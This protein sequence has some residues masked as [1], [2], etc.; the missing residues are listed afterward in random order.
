ME[1]NYNQFYSSY[2]TYEGSRTIDYKALNISLMA[3]YYLFLSDKSKIFIKGGVHSI[4][5][6][7]FNSH[8]FFQSNDDW[9]YNFVV[10]EQRPNI[11]MGVGTEY[12]RFF[13]E[14]EYFTNQNVL[15]N[16]L[17]VPTNL[18]R[19]SLSIGYKIFKL[20]SKDK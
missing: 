15:A 6:D 18:S 10:E 4:Y 1:S 19:L 17:S 12:R 20:S 13:A 3:K 8:Y 5:A 7:N 9:I 11:V 2:K 14:F 16:S